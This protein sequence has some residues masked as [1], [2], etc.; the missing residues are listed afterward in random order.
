MINCDLV[1]YA[2]QKKLWIRMPEIWVDNTFKD[3]YCYWPCQE[4]SLA[5]QEEC[6]KQ[7]KEKFKIDIDKIEKLHREAAKKRGYHRNV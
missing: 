4:K 2:P 3:R 5:F 7:I 6:L 1:Y